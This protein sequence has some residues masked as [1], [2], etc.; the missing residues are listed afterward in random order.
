MSLLSRRRFERDIADL[1]DQFLSGR[2]KE[3]CNQFPEFA[4]SLSIFR[5]FLTR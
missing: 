4:T 5:I 3:E 1:P 2:G